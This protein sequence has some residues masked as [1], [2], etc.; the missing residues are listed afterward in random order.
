[1]GADAVLLGAVAATAGGICL[2]VP[3]QRIDERWL[4][5]VPAFAVTQIA[6]AAVAVDGVLNSLYVTVALYV[7]LVFPPSVV[8]GFVAAIVTALAL[9]FAY[10]NQPAKETA[11]W[12]LV[13]GPAVIFIA[14]TTGVLMGRLHTSRETYRELAIVDGLTGVGNYR[15]LMERLEHEIR[16][17]HRRGREFT[18]LTL[19]LDGFKSV[20]DT[21]GHLVGDAVLTTVAAL[22]NVQVRTE[23]GVFRQGGDEFCVVAPETGQRG[24]QLLASRIA[25]ALNGVTSG[26]VR[27]SATIG[28]A[29]YPVHGTEA[30]ELLEVADRDL[31]SHRPAPAESGGRLG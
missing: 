25:N 3:W 30:G 2:L 13:V 12:L 16:R 5:A 26:T 9:P 17:H 7:A 11:T 28:R 19:D 15:G 31:R 22:I 20:N 29:L 21:H 8:A 4:V 14:A 27:L 6:I 1:M 23:D 10:A 24:G 18:V